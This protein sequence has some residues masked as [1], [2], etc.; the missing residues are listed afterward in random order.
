MVSESQQRTKIHRG[1]PVSDLDTKNALLMAQHD[2]TLA[3]EGYGEMEVAKRADTYYGPKLTLWDGERNYRLVPAGF[4]NDPELWKA[5]TDEEGFI[6]GWE[7]VDNVSVELSEIGARVQ[8]ECGELLETRQ[9]KR[10]AIGG[11]YHG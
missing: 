1:E 11:C 4:A 9:E 6:K 2:A 7:F 3:L 10:M 5:L 8:C